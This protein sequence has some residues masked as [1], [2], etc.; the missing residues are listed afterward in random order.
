MVPDLPRTKHT[1]EPRERSDMN[2]TSRMPTVATL[3][4][5]LALIAT[6][7][8]GDTAETTTTRA[9]TTTQAPTTTEALAAMVEVTAVDYGY[10]GLPASIAAG[11]TL[12]LVNESDEE[13]H[14]IVA[15][16]L[17]DDETRSAEELVGDPEGLQALFPSVST[18]ILAPPGETGFAVVGTGELN[19]PGRYLIIC[20]I[21][22]GADPD[23]YL[24]AAAESEGGP[25]EVEG[26]PPHFVVGMFT[27]VVVGG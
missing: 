23:E 1:H 27:E 20:A 11:T 18:V 7:C 24:A 13:L 6:A 21:P 4:L 15:I 12:S 26:G 5:V 25:P 19:E 9:P 16:R 8:G 3:V 17:D 10:E 14:E 22:T 2:H